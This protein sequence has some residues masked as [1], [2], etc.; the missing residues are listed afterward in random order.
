MV[1]PIEGLNY[2]SGF[3]YIVTSLDV[4][5]RCTQLSLMMG[6]QV[7]GCDEPTR[8]SFSKAFVV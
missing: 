6:H 7:I 1:F 5:L 2:T 3:V 8:T 4:S